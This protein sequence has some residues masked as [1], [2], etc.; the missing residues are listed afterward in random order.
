MEILEFDF[1]PDAAAFLPGLGIEPGSDEA[2]DFLALAE[3]A[4]KVARPKAAV[5]AA[6][7]GSISGDG[8]VSLGGVEFES[9][10]LADNLDGID[11]VWPY[12]ATCGRELYDWR[13]AI[14]DP[15]EGYWAE[16]LMQWAL[17]RAITGLTLHFGTA[18]YSGK[19]ADMTPGSLKEWPI[20]QQTPLFRL[21]G[22]AP[23]RAGLELTDSLLMLPNK[24]VS[25]IRFPNEHGYVNCRLCPRENCPNRRVPF[26]AGATH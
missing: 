12:F 6:R 17:A 13:M 8:R 24:S 18:F 19:T 21:F 3:A 9:L 15:F 1:A 25:G 14:P 10:L 16:E 26:E 5:T 22:D 4:V 11:T 7:V 23:A 20:Q 2:D